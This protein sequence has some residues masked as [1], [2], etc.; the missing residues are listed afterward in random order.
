MGLLATN[1]IAQGD[2][3]EVG[4]DQLTEQG[5][6]IVR[7][8]KSRP[9]PGG[10]NLEVSHVWLR[11]GHF[12]GTRI[13]DGKPVPAIGPYLARPG[14]T[15][16]KPHRLAANKGK[17]FQD[18]IVLGMGFILT[19]EEARA[20]IAK[21]P[22]NQEVLYPYL[23]G[24]DLNSRPDQSPSRWVIN[25]HD[26]PLERAEQYPDCLA[27]VREKV[28]PEREKNNRK[29]Y[30]AYWWQY[31]EKRPKLYA[32]IAGL[33]R[34]LI[35]ARVSKHH[36]FAPLH[37]GVVFC[38]QLVVVSTDATATLGLLQCTAH[39][40]WVLAYQSSLESRGRYTPS[41]CFETF[42]FPDD[43]APLEQIGE[44]YHHHRRQIMLARNEGL[45]KT[46]NRFQDPREHAADIETLRKLHVEMDLAV[47]AAYGWSD[48]DP[49][50]D[51]HQTRQGLRFTF[52]DAARRDLLDRLLALNH[53]RYQGEVARGLH[54][55]Q[56]PKRKGRTRT[57]RLPF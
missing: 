12:Q 33:E 52:A 23:N 32:T 20:L 19:H 40:A 55:K 35:T 29:V 39:E 2:T 1:T 11:R 27:I 14:T 34:L 13:L 53:T 43:T 46:Y 30:R 41:D 37:T 24:K 22:R 45:T 4:L 18:S 26:W 3:R 28:K 54:A 47:L 17:S 42:P 38:Q 21:D 10:A 16:G 49:G 6:T 51:F 7:A 56:S 31:A 25:F 36:L 8:V 48:L 9:W 57:P 50:H 44:C 5:F 15:R